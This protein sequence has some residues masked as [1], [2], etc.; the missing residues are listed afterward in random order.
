MVNIAYS[1]VLEAF[2]W[3]QCYSQPFSHVVKGV[4]ENTTA[5]VCR[6][7]DVPVSLGDQQGAGTCVR[8]NFYVLNCP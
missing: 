5:V 4:G 6:L 1:G 3:L 7:V 2:P 8:T